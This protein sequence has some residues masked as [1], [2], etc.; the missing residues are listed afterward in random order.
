[1]SNL[2]CRWLG[3]FACA[4]ALVATEAG[5]QQRP[6]RITVAA[7]LS[8]GS[9]W[10][11]ES[12]LGWGPILG[13][14]VRYQPWERWGFEF[15]TRRY[16]YKRRFP[17]SG[18]VFAGEGVAFTGG[19]TYHL[20]TSGPRPFVSGGIGILRSKRESR[21]PIDAPLS[22]LQFPRGAPPIIGEE[23]FHS[24]GTDAG[25]SVGGGVDVPLGSR[26]L[27]RPE[28]RTLFGAGSVLS[29]L[30]LGAS[31]ALGW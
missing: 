18:V 26:W 7:S 20:R 8:L 14:A 12:R 9:F 1:M 15:D 17:T 11:D 10:G 23:V 6:K 3:E 30:D 21:Y 16:T 25:L 4:V 19:V 31:L 22:S 27:L 13:V 29:P 2:H 24:T 28:V 5:A